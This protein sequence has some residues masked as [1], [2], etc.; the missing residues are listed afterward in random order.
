MNHPPTLSGKVP[1]VSHELA[2]FVLTAT[3]DGL[4]QQ[5]RRE[6]LRAHLNWVA[7]ALG[8]ARTVTADVAIRGIAAMGASALAHA[9]APD[10]TRGKLGAGSGPIAGPLDNQND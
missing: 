5:V 9:A 7:C 1:A 3:W 6:T 8:G 10:R 4:P 2:D